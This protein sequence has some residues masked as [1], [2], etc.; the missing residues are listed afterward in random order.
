MPDDIEEV[1]QETVEGLEANRIA[2]NH[3]FDEATGTREELA[4][5]LEFLRKERANE[6]AKNVS[7]TAREVSKER[8]K[9]ATEVAYAAGAEAARIDERLGHLDSAVLRINGS[10]EKTGNAL[11]TLRDETQDSVYGLRRDMQERFDNQ[12]AT[13]LETKT[14]GR[15]LI[16]QVFSA[17]LVATIGAAAVI[18]VALINSSP[19]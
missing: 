12:V 9:L 15:R 16:L 2:S 8:Q 13:A 4:K 17:V 6:I 18:V 19:V 10:I 3:K 1:R 5:E 14:E 7:D 11:N